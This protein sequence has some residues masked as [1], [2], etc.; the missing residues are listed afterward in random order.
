MNTL[1]LTSLFN[2]IDKFS[3]ENA[4]VRVHHEVID[5]YTLSFVIIARLK[6]KNSIEDYDGW[7]SFKKDKCITKYETP[8]HNYRIF[9]DGFIPV[10]EIDF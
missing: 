10:Y 1:F 2:T 4:Y 9:I 8:F 7:Y 3:N 5:I 6:L